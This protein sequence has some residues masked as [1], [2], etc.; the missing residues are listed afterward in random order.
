VE[1]VTASSSSIVMEGAVF[2]KTLLPIYRST[3]P[4]H[5]RR[6][7]PSESHFSQSILS[8]LSAI[9]SFTRRDSQCLSILAQELW[10]STCYVACY[11]HNS[12]GQALASH[13]GALRSLPGDLSETADIKHITTSAF[14]LSPD[15]RLVIN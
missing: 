12:G 1:P 8:L 15:R 6:P 3:L 7:H 14:H 4:L 5:T 2:F 13:C 10:Q 11:C 9:Q